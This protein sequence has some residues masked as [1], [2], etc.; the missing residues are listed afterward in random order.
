MRHFFR[1]S[2]DEIAMEIR[3]LFLDGEELNYTAVEANHLALLRAACRY[4]G[5][6][7]DA[8]EFSGLD[9]DKI[10]KYQAWTKA[11]IV[12]RIQ[13]LHRKEADLSWRNVSTKVDPALAAAAIRPN[14]FGSWRGALEAAGLNYDLIRRYRA[15]DENLVIREMRELHK[16]GE[17]LNSRGVQ[18]SAPPL[19]HAA[20]RR[21]EGWDSALEA[22]GLDASRIRKRSR[23]RTPREL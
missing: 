2:K 16:A 4:F 5:S 10:R 8:V 11:K 13:E 19:F 18:E 7:K 9:Y 3:G 17:A 6:W 1:W 21:F 14:R 12:E 15:W 20:R 22:A 23:A